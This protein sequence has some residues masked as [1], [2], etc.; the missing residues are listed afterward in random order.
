MRELNGQ[1]SLV[2]FLKL[3]IELAK[4]HPEEVDK[5]VLKRSLITTTSTFGKN[6]TDCCSALGITVESVM[7]NKNFQVKCS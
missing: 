7:N 1:F 6:L 2:S 5:A 3:F 4:H